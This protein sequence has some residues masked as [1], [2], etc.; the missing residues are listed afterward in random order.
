MRGKFSGCSVILES[1]VSIL[2]RKHHPGE[3]ELQV[4]GMKLKFLFCG[5]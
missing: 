4:N 3:Y 1:Y 2:I 5:I